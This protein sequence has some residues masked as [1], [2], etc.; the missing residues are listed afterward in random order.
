MTSNE[1]WGLASVVIPTRNRATYLKKALDSVYAQSYQNF[2]IIVVN[3][4]STD[5]TANIA[6]QYD[7]RLRYY[8]Q[9][10]QGVSAARNRGI[11]EAKGEI[12]A[13]LDDDDLF[14]P[15]RLEKGV[16]YLNRYPQVVWLCSGFSFIDAQG[17]AAN[18]PPIIPEKSEITLHDI[19]MFTFI[20]TSSVIIRK[21]SLQAAGGFP[22][23]VKV[24]EDYHTWARVLKTGQ[25]AALKDVLTQFRLHPGNTKL[26]YRA[27]L[28]EN[29]RILDGILKE[30]GIGLRPRQEYISNLHR[31]IADSLWHKGK[32]LSYIIF[33][34]LHGKNY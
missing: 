1:T 21:A 6:E 14:L 19:A 28:E 2:E 27:L 15:G 9:P 8:G 4:G 26:P 16:D 18:R 5:S 25:G 30:G 29:T 32:Y 10:H 7:T 17:N 12:I 24:S 23:G 11:A 3:D 22:D 13:F 20:H 33:A 31:I 34:L